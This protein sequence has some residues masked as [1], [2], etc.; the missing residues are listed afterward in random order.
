VTGVVENID[1]RSILL[2]YWSNH[3]SC[4]CRDQRWRQYR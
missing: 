2:Y 1:K 4:W 3:F